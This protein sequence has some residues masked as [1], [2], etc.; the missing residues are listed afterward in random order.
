MSQ[1]TRLV[2]GTICLIQAL[3]L[4]N[5][6]VVV[7]FLIA[8]VCIRF[9]F[10]KD[11]FPFPTRGVRCNVSPLHCVISTTRAKD[12]PPSNRYTSRVDGVSTNIFENRRGRVGNRRGRDRVLRAGNAGGRGLCHVFEFASD[13]H[14]GCNRRQDQYA[15]RMKEVCNVQRVE[16]CVVYRGV[17][18]STTRSTRGVRSPRVAN[19]GRVRRRAT[20]P[21]RPRRIRRRVGCAYVRRRVNRR[22]PKLTSGYLGPYQR[23]RPIRPKGEQRARG[24]RCGTHRYDRSGRSSV[25]MRR[26]H[27]GISPA[28]VFFRVDCGAISYR[29][30]SSGEWSKSIRETCH[31]SRRDRRLHRLHPIPKAA[32]M[33]RGQSRGASP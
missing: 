1:F 12:G 32:P 15:R 28:R 9:Q 13:H 2:R 14:R 23:F 3:L 11:Q 24:C 27:S 6:V 10:P 7:F 8:M 17:R 30:F 18:R 16:G 19:Q 33:R 21:M 29:S 22:Q 20:R 25:S 4:A 26:L 31:P 5:V